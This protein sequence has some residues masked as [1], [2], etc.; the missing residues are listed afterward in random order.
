MTKEERFKMDMID[1]FK[2]ICTHVEKDGVIIAHK[3]QMLEALKNSLALDQ[4]RAE[5]EQTDFDFGD[6]YD[7]TEDI[8]GLVVEVI[9]KY[10]S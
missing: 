6:Y 5:I 2:A 9:D 10:K 4:I 8:R 1:E 7:H 3:T